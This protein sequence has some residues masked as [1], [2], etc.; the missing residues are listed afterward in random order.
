MA[1]EKTGFEG[2]FLDLIEKKLLDFNPE[3]QG[4]KGVFLDL[5]EKRLLDFNPEKSGFTGI[6]LSYDPN[7]RFVK[8]ED[9]RGNPLANTQVRVNNTVP[10][11]YTTDS[12]GIAEIFI[13]TGATVTVDVTHYKYSKPAISFDSVNELTKIIK[14]SSTTQH[15]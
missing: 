4:F 14:L 13:D 3:T 10:T 1:V 15:L 7:A 8:V 2:L 12:N 5:I 9:F 6:I 11:T